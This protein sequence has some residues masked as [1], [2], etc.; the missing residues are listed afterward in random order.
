MTSAAFDV[1][2]ERGPEIVVAEPKDARIAERIRALRGRCWEPSRRVWLVPVTH[3]PAVIRLAEEFG[4]ALHPEVSNPEPTACAYCWHKRHYHGQ[5][6]CVAEGCDCRTFAASAED[7]SCMHCGNPPSGCR[8]PGGYVHP[9]PLGLGGPKNGRSQV[10]RLR[11]PG[12]PQ[13]LRRSNG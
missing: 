8:C 7:V 9:N 6:G 3:A 5:S 4:L 1:W 13:P 11:R 2:V 10:V 12:M